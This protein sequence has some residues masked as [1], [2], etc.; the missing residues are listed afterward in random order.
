MRPIAQRP[1]LLLATTV[2][3]ASLVVSASAQR[4]RMNPEFPPGLAEARLVKEHAVDLGVGE[5]ALAK[6][7][8]IVAD[9]KPREEELREKGAKAR[10]DLRALLDRPLPSEKA[11]MDAAAAVVEVGLETRKLKLRCS[12]HVRALLTVE[13]LTKFMKLR[14]EAIGAKPS[15]DYDEALGGGFLNPEQFVSLVYLSLT[16]GE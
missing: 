4:R 6:L 12:L 1:L 16:K 8:A 10:S 2:L 9:V 14:E 7:D 3:V 15:A 11:L 13:Q 5:E